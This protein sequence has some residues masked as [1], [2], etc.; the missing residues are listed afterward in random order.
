MKAKQL[1][2]VL[3]AGCC[4]TIAAFFGVGFLADKMLAGQ[5][6]K[7]SA[8]RALNNTAETQQASLIKDKKDIAKYSSLNTIAASIVPQDKDQA[9][10][11][12]QIVNIATANGISQLSSI[13][14]PASTLGATTGAAKASAS[15][16]NNLTQLT[17]VPGINGVYNLAITITQSANTP[18][19]YTDFINFLSGL[20]KNRRT[21]QV[22][23]VTLQPDAKNPNNVSFTL[24]IN[25]FIK[26]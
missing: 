13:T 18:V 21:A 25:E 17:P 15:T 3:L 5:A 8:L 4:L 7:L 26:P 16:P 19:P 20:E 9:E 12:R 1:Y 2:Y 14:F 6:S 24:V 11:V 10:A 23:S 22:T